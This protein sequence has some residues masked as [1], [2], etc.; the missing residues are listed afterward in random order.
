MD[1]A[2]L[3]RLMKEGHVISGTYLSVDKKYLNDIYTNLRDRPKVAEVTIMDQV[4]KQ[5]YKTF[6]ENILVYTFIVTIFAGVIAFGVVY[7]S[8]RISLSERS[9]EMASLRVL[10]FTRTEI[11]YI[12]L[13]ELAIL[14]LVAIPIGFFI[15]YGLA[16]YL[17]EALKTDLYR[18]PLII[19]ARTYSFSSLIVI[20]SAT[21]SGFIVRHRLDHLDLIEVLK[22]RE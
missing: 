13:G 11:S 21:V 3:N 6:G 14:T 8:A 12:L 15:G 20:I 4:K 7:N 9:R 16:A 19:E 10:G 5:I 18:V 2:A 1:I 22:T 17:I